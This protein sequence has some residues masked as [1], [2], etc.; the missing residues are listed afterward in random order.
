ML[1]VPAGPCCV[2]PGF[3]A[4]WKPQNCLLTDQ[5]EEGDLRAPPEQ[6]GPLEAPVFRKD[7]QDDIM[8]WTHFPY[9]WPFVQGIRQLL[10]DSQHKEPMMQ[11]FGVFF[12]DNLDKF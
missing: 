6:C 11:N 10:V 9:Y 8:T 7:E 3:E 4:Q 1:T 12:V 5:S 2:I